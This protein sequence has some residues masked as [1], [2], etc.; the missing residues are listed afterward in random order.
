M[1]RHKDEA[2]DMSAYGCNGSAATILDDNSVIVRT[3]KQQTATQV[4]QRKTDYVLSE[5]VSDHYAVG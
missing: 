1:S 5:T 4:T 2:V 3:V